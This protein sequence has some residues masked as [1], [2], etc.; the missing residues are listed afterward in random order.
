MQGIA[1]VPGR[2]R[3]VLLPTRRSG[4]CYCWI[5]L[6][7]H[8]TCQPFQQ[9][10]SGA[11]EYHPDF[12]SLSCCK[13]ASDWIA[14]Q[15]EAEQLG[16]LLMVMLMLLK[17]CCCWE[18]CRCWGGWTWAGLK[19]SLANRADSVYQQ[20]THKTNPD[21]PPF[22]FIPEIKKWR[23]NKNQGLRPRRS[24]LLQTLSCQPS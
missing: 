23:R 18:G 6:C 8:D 20:R 17:G 19:S 3:T 14:E 5:L 13:K 2:D 12:F 24:Q 22:L 10:W 21:E 16:E 4:A 1:N 9:R 15:D 11:D 7:S